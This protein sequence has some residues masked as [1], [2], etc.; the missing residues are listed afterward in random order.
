MN[1]GSHTDSVVAVAAVLVNVATPG[2]RQGRPYPAPSG[3]DLVIG[4]RGALQAGNRL[5]TSAPAAS[6]MP[7]FVE[8]AH[9]VRPVFE[10]VD[11][12]RIDDAAIIVND[13]LSRYAPSPYLDRHD[14]QPWHLHFHGRNAA[15]RSGWGGGVSVGLAAVLGS[16]YADRLGVCRAPSCDRVFVDVSRNG[17]RRFCSTACQNRV[18]A[19]AHRARVRARVD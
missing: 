14:Q 12:G 16:E 2:E 1:F 13:L 18:K 19:T 10:A 6:H 15:D 17:T 5:P 4:V 3:R 11:V 8:L 7:A 9:S